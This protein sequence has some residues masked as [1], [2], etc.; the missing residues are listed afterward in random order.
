TYLVSSRL[1]SVSLNPAEA[2]PIA[3]PRHDELKGA[4]DF[5][6]IKLSNGARL[7]LQP[8]SRLPNLHLRLAC[9]GGPLYET[10]GKRGA[11][12]LLAT[13][14]TKDTRKRSAAQVAQAIE[15]V[16]GAFHS[17]SGNNVFGLAIEVLPTDV[18]RALAL[19][20]EAVFS[21]AFRQQTFSTERGAQIAELQQEADDIVTFGKK[22]LRKKFFGSHPFAIDAAG[23]EPGLRA[24]E[25]RAL[26]ELH[27]ALM[28]GS[29]AVLALAGD[30]SVKKLAPKL[31][32]FLKGF[33]RAA[34]PS[35]SPR[36]SGPASGEFTEKQP[37]EQAVVFQAFSGPPLLHDDFYVGEVADEL[38]S[39]MASR[40]FER[41]REEKGLAYFVRS[42]RIT[43]L[44][45][46]MFYFYA[47]T[48]PAHVNEVFVEIEAEI[49]R[50]QSG[51]VEEAELSR[52]QVR[53]KAGRRQSLQPNSARAM[54]AALNALY[55]LPI[56]DWKNYD[57]RID[58]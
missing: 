40:L 19:L 23:D 3:G 35:P 53:L 38:F 24:L 16:G 36:F 22:L 7:L 51:G 20:S 56:N 52:C 2:A 10:P 21:P 11:T 30:F 33:P 29:N 57:A 54:H 45:T 5:Q 44:D 13:L 6:E 39:G 17:F 46:A 58:A 27:R 28:I 8:D 37:R 48:A 49:S 15:E 31:R 47:G 9:L 25:P 14:L 4:P 43:G 41:V 34:A 55:G 26:A 32:A 12:A 18:D 1:T 50:V 42:E